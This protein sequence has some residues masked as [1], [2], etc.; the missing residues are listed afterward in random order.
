LAGK[1]RYCRKPISIQHPVVEMITGILFGWW[2]V[3]GFAFFR[4]TAHPLLYIQPVYWL[5]VGI[6]LLIILITD[7]TNFIIP[8]F[9]VVLL[10]GFALG[11]RW[12]LVGM[13]VMSPIDLSTALAAGAGLAGFFIGLIILTRGRGMGWGD[14]KLALALGLILG[15]PRALIAVFLAFISG[16]LIGI[17]LVVTGR[18]TLRQTMPFGPFLVAGT[19]AAL[20]WGYDVWLWYLRLLGTG[21]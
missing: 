16:A 6:L 2:Y 11:Y 20:M 7:L 9:A 14:V 13:G 1:C 3:V 10:S 17:G 12:L 4:L 5:V 8:D 21:G 15:W 19:V 18:R